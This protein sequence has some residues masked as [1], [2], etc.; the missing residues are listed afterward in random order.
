MKWIINNDYIMGQTKEIVLTDKKIAGFDLDDT[1]IKAKGENKF[2]TSFDDWEF[3]DKNIPQKLLKL[4]LDKYELVIITNQKGLTT[5]KTD[6]KTFQKKIKLIKTKLGLDFT[7]LISPLDNQYRKPRTTLWD[8]VIKGDVPNSF[9]CGDAGGL[10][11]R[12]IGTRIIERDFSDTDAKFAKNIGLKF[13]HRDEFV[14]GNQYQNN[15]MLSYPVDFET[16]Q[17]NGYQFTKSDFQKVVINVGFPASGKTTFTKKY[18]IPNG[19]EY[20]NQDTLKTQKKCIETFVTL[21]KKGKNIIIDNT[22]LTKEIRKIYLDICKENKVNCSCLLFSTPKEICMHNSYYRNFITNGE[23]DV[24]N[25]IV[26]NVMNKKYEIPTK[27]EGFY[28]IIEIKFCIDT[29]DD[30]IYRKYYF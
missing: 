8:Q 9:F 12:I 30:T 7:I 20:V 15:C 22:N 17:K 26:Y 6:L 24:I 21:L 2:S 28:D 14:F 23:I 10:N 3:Y 25:R 29:D 11:K 4:V 19:Y 18:M 1:I 13:I 27:D 5:G 16:V